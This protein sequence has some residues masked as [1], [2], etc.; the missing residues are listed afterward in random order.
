MTVSPDFRINSVLLPS[1][2]EP[3]WVEPDEKG[4]NGVGQTLYQPFFSFE[5]SWNRLSQEDF[6]TLMRVWKGHYGSGSAVVRLPEYPATTYG[7]INYTGVY[8][9]RPKQGRSYDNN[10]TSD[11][12]LTI[13][14]IDINATN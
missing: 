12:K 1:P 13:R 4:S 5:L 6:Y 3:H 9:D 11:V 7:F 10:Y 2:T 14:R 8:I